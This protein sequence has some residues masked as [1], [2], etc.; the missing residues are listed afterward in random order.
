MGRTNRIGLTRAL[1]LSVV[2]FYMVS[3][4]GSEQF[5]SLIVKKW[6]LAVVISNVLRWT[7]DQRSWN[8]A[9]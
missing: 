2:R 3:S 1:I 5:F 8:G 6:T 4:N 9:V 7:N